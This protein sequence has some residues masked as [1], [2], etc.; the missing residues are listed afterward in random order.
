MTDQLIT[1]DHSGQPAQRQ[2]AQIQPALAELD[3]AARQG[4]FHVLQ[5]RMEPVWEAWGLDLPDESVVVVPSITVSRGVATGSALTQAFEERLLFLLLLLRQP[6]LRMIYVTSAPINP[7]IIEYYLALLPGVIPSHALARLTLIAADDSTDRA[8][9]EKLLE[10]PRLL[11]KIAAQIPNRERCHLIPYNTTSLERD[12]ALT[13]GI[14]MYGADPRLAD[15]GTKSGCRRLFAE[16][17]V[18]HPLGAEGLH[19]VAEVTDAIKVMIATRPTIGEVIIKTNEGVSGAGNALVDLAG[20][21]DLPEDQRAAAID[22]RVRAM[23]LESTTIPLDTYVAKFEKGG[24]IVEERIVGETLLSP[25]VQLRARPDGSVELLSTH[26][27]LLGGASGQSYLGCLF[28]ADPA[29]SRLISEPAQRIGE[30]LAAAGAL[31]RFAI[32]FVV[33]SDGSGEWSAYAIELNLRKGGTTHP[34]LTLQFLT[35]GGY[36][37]ASGRFLTQQGHERHLVATDHLESDDLRALS[38]DD[39]FDVVARHGLHFDESTQTGVVFHMI[40]CLSECGR[41]G[42]TTVGET[43]EQ[44]MAIYERAQRILLDEA[45]DARQEGRLPG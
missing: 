23:Q 39:L 44:A 28:P 45:R 19:S 42:M 37:A 12:L 3:D 14:P 17:G 6:R 22:I 1:D 10:R 18:P 13:L 35:D 36:D 33:V 27:Q 41:V 31:G 40:S 8:L 24:G 5:Q 15:L 25:S 16:C 43:P 38:V 32:D 2:P 7:R 21:V 9:S 4:R 34:F 11:A 29:Y 20:I 30:R 26:D